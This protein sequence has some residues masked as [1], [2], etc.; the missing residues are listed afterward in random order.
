MFESKEETFRVIALKCSEVNEIRRKR[1][2]LECEIQQLKSEYN[3]S[4]AI[5]R[6]LS[7]TAHLIFK[8]LSFNDLLICEQVCRAW[9]QHVKGQNIQTLV[10]IKRLRSHPE[11][12]RITRIRPRKGFFCGDEHHFPSS[13]ML[14]S[15][16]NIKLENSFLLGL[17]QLKVA[18]PSLRLISN[19]KLDEPLLI[20][21]SFL[22]HFV[23]LETLEVSR[24]E[25]DL[26]CT[27]RLPELKNLAIGRSSSRTV[28]DCPKLTHYRHKKNAYR[29]EI[30]FVHPESVTHLYA[31]ELQG[32]YVTFK[33]LQY[34]CVSSSSF[35]EEGLY[36]KYIGRSN[37]WA[38]IVI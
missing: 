33:N 30:E 20:D 12:G 29:G 28:I 35:H 18:N 37:F 31:N 14:L 13:P 9:N 36:A 15:N 2:D 25:F 10:I 3:E 19:L 22:N 4:L 17:K 38:T 21:P 8:W 24:L 32:V 16:C 7:K 27:L 5:N 34:M 26:D 1:A 6:L 11:Y 23:N